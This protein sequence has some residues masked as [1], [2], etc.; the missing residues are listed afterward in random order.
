MNPIQTNASFQT[1]YNHTNHSS[2]RS[3]QRGVDNESI[4]FILNNA[5]P[6]YRQGFCFFSL[7]STGKKEVPK[8]LKRESLM[9]LVVMTC[10]DG[11]AI[12][13]VYKNLKAWKKIKRK[14]KY[15]S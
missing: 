4:A 13:T 7:K 1:N 2:K 10:A 14:H 12:I 6:I 8:M 11:E 5:A 15:L 3:K 9:N